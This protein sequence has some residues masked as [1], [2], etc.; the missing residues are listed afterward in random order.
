MG[1]AKYA[2]F[3]VKWSYSRDVQRV[4]LVVRAEWVGIVEKEACRDVSHFL[5]R[6]NKKQLMSLVTRL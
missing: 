1:L 6:A 5:K 2:R 3:F 4:D